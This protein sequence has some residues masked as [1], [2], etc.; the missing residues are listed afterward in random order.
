VILGLN[1][2]SWA[3]PGPEWAAFH[4][5]ANDGRL[6][7]A[8][9]GTGAQG[10]YMTDL[11]TDWNES[12]SGTVASKLKTE[13]NFAKECI[14]KLRAE[15]N[16][17]GHAPKTILCCGGTVFK[18]AKELGCEPGY[19]IHR[20]THYAYTRKEFRDTDFYVHHVHES[21]GGGGLTIPGSD[22]DTS[23]AARPLIDPEAAQDNAGDP[24]DPPVVGVGE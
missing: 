7:L 5:S 22:I 21:L 3:T 23:E 17:L 8:V 1:P 10:A 15:L 11:V 4:N 12:S 19:Q 20:I 16:D 14:S 9:H 18:H 6:A 2:A 13:P 24:D